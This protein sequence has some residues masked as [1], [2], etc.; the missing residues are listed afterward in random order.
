MF[1]DRQATASQLRLAFKQAEEAQ[2]PRP[3]Q[4][5]KTLLPAYAAKFASAWKVREKTREVAW[6][7]AM[8][9]VPD[10]TGWDTLPIG[11]KNGEA[12]ANE[13]EMQLGILRDIFDSYYVIAKNTHKNRSWV[14][15]NVRSLAQRL[16][17]QQGNVTYG[18]L[19]GALEAAGCVDDTILSHC[20]QDAIHVRGCWLLDFIIGLE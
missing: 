17:S 12:L 7:T 11:S 19:A 9:F 20:R 4:P 1:A 5:W 8:I 15:P 16:Y 18:I 3:G 6:A 10:A 13:V 14:N 2:Q